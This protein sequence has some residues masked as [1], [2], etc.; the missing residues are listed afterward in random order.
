[1]IDDGLQFQLVPWRPALEQNLGQHGAGTM[2]PCEAAR[3]LLNKADNEHSGVLSTAK[4]HCGHCPSPGAV[5]AFDRTVT[6]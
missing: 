6:L 1:M 3:E 4:S 2:T 5:R